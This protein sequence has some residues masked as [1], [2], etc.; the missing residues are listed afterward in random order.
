MKHT[1]NMA[2][3]MA[4][5]AATPAVA[6][7]QNDTAAAKVFE[8]AQQATLDRWAAQSTRAPNRTESERAMQAVLDQINQR[9]C[10]GAV[11]KL[12]E[13]LAN[14]Y[15]D[16]YYLAGALYEEGICLKPNW[17]RAVTMYHRAYEGGRA[18]A[19]SR[20]SSG[21]AATVGGQDRAAALWWA[22][23]A[24]QQLPG[25]CQEVAPLLGDADK[26]VDALRHW[27]AGRLEA[28]AYVAGVMTTIKGDVDYPRLAADHGLQG[29][30]SL[31]F[32]PAQAKIAITGQTVEMQDLGGYVSGDVQRDR[33]SR[34]VRESFSVYLRQ[35]A[36]R[37][38]ARYPKPAVVPGDWQVQ[39]SYEFKFE[40]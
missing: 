16:V 32:M 6:L 30:V 31:D 17:D 26:F 19:A 1:A 22:I 3:A 12:N 33:E 36:D 23:K 8:S 9:D 20:I 24:G 14:A 28:C 29:S 2:V 25:A 7:A 39:A 10:A 18:E 34:R 38:L 4:L 21:Y 27:P 37:A 5:A 40:K 35:I 15:R 11:R 13:G